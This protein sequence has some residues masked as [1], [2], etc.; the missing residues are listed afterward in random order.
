MKDRLFNTD[1]K[2]EKAIIT[3]R[4]GVNTPFWKLMCKI[5]K[6]NIKVLTMLILDGTN[7]D[8]EPASKKETDRMR[9]K[10]KV[11]REVRDT[12]TKMVEVLTSEEAEEP[13]FDPYYSVS[14]LKKE[15]EKL[16]E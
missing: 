13:S 15:R 3:F 5:L 10:L 16:G 14:D 11:Y 1:K 4:D 9:D 6:A 12:P 8:G 7:F 2:K